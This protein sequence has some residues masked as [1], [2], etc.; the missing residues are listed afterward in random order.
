[1]KKKLLLSTLTLSVLFGSTAFAKDISVTIDN[2]NIVFD[3]S[4][5]IE[6]GRTL[7]PMRGIFEAFSAQ[8]EWDEKAKTITATKGTTIIKMQIDSTKM[9]VNGIEKTL[10]VSPVIIGGRT[11]VPVR[12]MS[13]SLGVEIAWDN[14]TQTVLIGEGAKSHISAS[15]IDETDPLIKIANQY[16]S[17]HET[18]NNYKDSVAK[19]KNPKTV[20]ELKENYNALAIYNVNQLPKKGE[21]DMVNVEQIVT[22]QPKMIMQSNIGASYP[23][24]YEK[25]KSKIL[26]AVKLDIY[27][28]QST[29][30]MQRV[31][32][33]SISTGEKY[34]LYQNDM[35]ELN[36]PIITNEYYNSGNEQSLLQIS[37]IAFKNN[38][39]VGRVD[40]R[41]QSSKF[42]IKS[43]D[44]T[45]SDGF[46]SIGLLIPCSN[47]YPN[48][49]YLSN[50][51]IKPNY[52]MTMIDL[53]NVEYELIQKERP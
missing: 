48:V 36:L 1:M 5:V 3:Q 46:D 47:F 6:N 15:T 17:S 27:D 45:Y 20:A 19:I 39:A 8:V 12:A 14:N 2:K 42:N 7:V 44:D 22:L 37:G 41:T 28:K 11:L 31:E 33:I 10:D 25:D 53:P 50:R 34:V 9:S 13:E 38:I 52:V 35:K 24:E 43:Y 40:I 49:K 4:P 51:T 18:F 16:L 23:I 30:K 32:Q 29:I 26:S 21:Y